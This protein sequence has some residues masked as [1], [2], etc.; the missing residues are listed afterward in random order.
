MLFTTFANALLTPRSSLKEKKENNQ[1]TLKKTTSTSTK[2]QIYRACL[3]CT[4]ER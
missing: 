1:L 2:R 3:T 4:N